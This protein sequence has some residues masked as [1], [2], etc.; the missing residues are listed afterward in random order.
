MEAQG[1]KPDIFRS[2]SCTIQKA[3]FG[4]ADRHKVLLGLTE[5][6]AAAVAT[7]IHIGSSRFRLW[8]SIILFHRR[9]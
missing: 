8:E 3:G 4:T 5:V 9:E 7:M 1:E 6:K 2:F